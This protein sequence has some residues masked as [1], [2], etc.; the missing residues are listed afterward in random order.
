MMHK[1]YLVFFS[2]MGPRAVALAA[3]A[4]MMLVRSA[5]GIK[6]EVDRSNLDRSIR[7]ASYLLEPS[8]CA[9]CASRDDQ[10][11]RQIK[12]YIPHF[13]KFHKV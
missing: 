5:D 9:L 6:R 10:I 11:A 7:A 13:V 8:A 12:N 4:A 3:V 1:N 2:R